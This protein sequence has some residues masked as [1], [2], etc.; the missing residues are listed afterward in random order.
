VLEGLATKYRSASSA[1]IVSQKKGGTLDSP[2]A[3]PQT[4]EVASCHRSPGALTY[5]KLGGFVQGNMAPHCTECITSN[6]PRIS[7][8]GLF[9]C[10]L[11]RRAIGDE[12]S[13]IGSGR[14]RRS[15]NIGLTELLNPSHMKT[16]FG[17]WIGRSNPFTRPS[18]PRTAY[19]MSFVSLPA[20]SHV[21]A[22][23]A[24]VSAAACGLWSDSILAPS[25]L[26]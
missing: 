6:W 22:S 13:K 26:S 12:C 15:I 14:L 3:V 17:Y 18:L 25:A 21:A 19:R 23:T 2:V 7:A 9:R 1:A 10:A 4:N 16:A 8:R 24:A 20:M 11:L 5:A